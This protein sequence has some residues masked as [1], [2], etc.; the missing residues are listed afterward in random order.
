[1]AEDTRAEHD[2][3][4]ARDHTHER[5]AQTGMGMEPAV[6]SPKE[7]IP[8]PSLL[9]DARL[10]QSANRPVNVALMLQAQRTYGNRALRRMLQAK[11]PGGAANVPDQIQRRE[12]KSGEKAQAQAD[13]IPPQVQEASGAHDAGPVAQRQTQPV[14]PIWGRRRDG[15]A[16]QDAPTRVNR[17]WARQSSNRDVVQRQLHIAALV[18]V[19]R[20]VGGVTIQRVLTAQQEQEYKTFVSKTY[21]WP[22]RRAGTNGK[23]DLVYDPVARRMDVT[24]KVKF[25]FPD[26]P[27]NTIPD[28]AIRTKYR[29]NYMQQVQTAWSNRYT[30]ENVRAPQEAWK[31]LN[32]V[33]V[34]VQVVE[35][36]ANPHFRI[37][38]YIKTTGT[39]RVSGGNA[40]AFNETELYKG[41]DTPQAEFNP[42]T[43]QGELARIQRINPSP[44]L[45]ANNASMVNAQYNDPLNF[46][47]TYIKRIKNPKFDIHIVGHASATRKGRSNRLLSYQRAKAVATF[48]ETN[49]LTNHNLVIEGVGHAGATKDAKKR[50]VEITAKVP[51]GWQN[52]QDATAHEFGHMVGLG[53]EYS[54]GSKAT[55][56]DLVSKAFG[57]KYADQVA[58]R[59]DTDYAS[60]MESGNDVRIQHYV[61]FWEALCETTLHKATVPNP[62]FG[63]KDWKFI[64]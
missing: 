58:K 2:L 6:F 55:H 5:P 29:N 43:E 32:P 4:L 49:G 64:G 30:F 42:G 7:G 11:R 22:N 41:D 62:K 15:G 18:P 12:E 26:V 19:S 17:L 63:Y 46:L 37:K 14:A 23:F 13:S 33:T 20:S 34:N 28:K 39:A 24:V 45:F 38:A 51:A 47:A 52:M 31:K 10:R 21:K 59:G 36:N 44:I 57:K 8:P 48:L 25:D 50:K 56:Y 16:A 27:G 60:I 9:N 53:D 40:K 3:P 54:G 1:M 35:D 61:T